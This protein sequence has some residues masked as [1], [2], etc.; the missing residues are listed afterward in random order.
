[1]IKRLVVFT[2]ILFAGW[3]MPLEAQILEPVKW[4][5]STEKVGER[6]YDLLFIAQIE[7]KWHLYSQDIPMS[8]PATVFSFEPSQAFAL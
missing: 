2:A 3:L 4:R 5:F 6:E 8:P 7:P 1:M